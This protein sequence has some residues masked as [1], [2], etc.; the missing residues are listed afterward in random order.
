MLIT[1]LTTV[2]MYSLLARHAREG[3][4]A[5]DNATMLG[6]AFL[7][8]TEHEYLVLPLDG[9]VLAQA[10]IL[11]GQYPLRTL[12]ALQLACAQRAGT[13]LGEAISFISSDR[14]LLAAASAEGLATDDPLA[15]P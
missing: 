13:I 11:V 3:S 2:E 6:H 1:E 10:R 9:Q 8:H 15:H 7:L 5:M 12:D 14:T 4:L